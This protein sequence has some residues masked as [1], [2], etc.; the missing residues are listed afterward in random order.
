MPIIF[1]LFQT[2]ERI[3]TDPAKSAVMAGSGLMRLYPDETRHGAAATVMNLPLKIGKK[4]EYVVG[5]IAR[6]VFCY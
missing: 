6:Y 2:Q 1:N 5:Y 3:R 4:T